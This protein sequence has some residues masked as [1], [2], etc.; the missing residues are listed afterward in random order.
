M[1]RVRRRMS[2][3]GIDDFG[4]YIDLLQVNAEE[5]SALFNTILINVTFFRDPDAW[6]FL[7]TEMVPML[8]AER[9]PEALST[10]RH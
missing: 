5:F 10:M 2:K 9:A 4:E 3:I 7:R 1:R 6:D 8:L